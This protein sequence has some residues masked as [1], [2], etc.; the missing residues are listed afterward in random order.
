MDMATPWDL[1]IAGQMIEGILAG[2]TD[3]IGVEMFYALVSLMAFGLIY[4]RVRNTGVVGIVAVLLGGSLLVILPVEV[5]RLAYF[6]IV[7]GIAAIIYK[8]Y[9]S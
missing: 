6:F 9:K 2:Y 7:L 8:I 4:T 3:V 1:L 5:Q